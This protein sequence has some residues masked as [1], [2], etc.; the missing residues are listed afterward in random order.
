MVKIKIND[1]SLESTVRHLL[2]LCSVP[3]NS[4]DILICDSPAPSEGYRGI[5][6][7]YSEK[8]YLSSADHRKLA[9]SFGQRYIPMEYPFSY[10]KLC[11]SLQQLLSPDD[12][13]AEPKVHPVSVSAD[14]TVSYKDASVRL[15]TREAELFS[16]LLEN[17]GHTATREELK[18]AVWKNET[19]PGTNI[20]DVYISY[21]RKKLLPL[22][23]KGF[24]QSEHGQGYF[25]TLPRE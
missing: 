4:G 9:N 2:A 1:K 12:N 21:L 23:G 19:D 15:S 8:N 5:I 7:L 24:I 14:G 17:G 20:V 25:L 13:G 16:Y 22:F 18:S 10:N 3:T 11:Q 6:V